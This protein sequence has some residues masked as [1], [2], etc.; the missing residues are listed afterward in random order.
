MKSELFRM[1]L[2]CSWYAIWE[3]AAGADLNETVLDKFTFSF[4]KQGQITLKG[5]KIFPELCAFRCKALQLRY[6]RIS[7]LTQ[8]FLFQKTRRKQLTEFMFTKAVS[9]T[10][11][12]MINAVYNDKPFDFY[13]G[14]TFK[15]IKA[16]SGTVLN[17]INAVYHDKPLIFIGASINGQWMKLIPVYFFEECRLK[18]V[19]Q[20]NKGIVL[21]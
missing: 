3:Q 2:Q 5:K 4:K 21:I 20:T 17:M 18:T 16:V 14:Y 19:A 15:F 7:G 13:R 10:V 12:N 9:G 11:S 6:K 8:D 1:H